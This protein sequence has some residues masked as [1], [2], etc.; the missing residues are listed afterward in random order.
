M[1]FH[2]R[3]RDE[4]EDQ[5]RNIS[6]E[7]EKIKNTMIWCLDRADSSDEVHM[8]LN[9]NLQSYLFMCLCIPFDRLLTALQRLCV[10]VKHLYL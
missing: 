7:R 5:L 2:C 10:S 6:M 1:R 8:T 4:L 9:S 3:R